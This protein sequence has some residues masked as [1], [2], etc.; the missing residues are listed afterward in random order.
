MQIAQLHQSGVASGTDAPKLDSLP[1][2]LNTGDS[3]VD[4]AATVLRLLYIADLR[5]LQSSVNEIIVALQEFTA[6]PKTDS[7]LGKLGR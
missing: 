4:A 1:L 6:D 7:R 5:E 3:V 2:G